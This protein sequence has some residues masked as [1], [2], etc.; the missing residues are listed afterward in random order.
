MKNI[1]SY[2]LFENAGSL[3]DSIMD[4]LCDITDDG[5]NVDENWLNQR[6]IEIGDS[7]IVYISKNGKN[8]ESRDIYLEFKLSEIKNCLDHLNSYLESFGYGCHII[9]KYPKLKSRIFDTYSDL[10]DNHYDE[11]KVEFIQLIFSKSNRYP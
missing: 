10:F 6:Y 3:Y 1:I 9:V 11:N 7:I 5:F 8:Q 2:K 4:I